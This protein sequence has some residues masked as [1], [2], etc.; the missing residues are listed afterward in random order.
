MQSVVRWRRFDVLFGVSAV[1]V[2]VGLGLSAPGAAEFGPREVIA[3]YPGDGGEVGQFAALAQDVEGH[4]HVA[5]YDALAGDLKYAFGYA[6]S[7]AAAI[8]WSRL[9]AA[10]EGDVGRHCDL[11]LTSSGNPVITFR[12]ETEG[13]LKAAFLVGT[14]TLGPDGTLLTPTEFTIETID[15]T[16]PN[17]GLYSS[18]AIDSQNL[19]HVAY[20][21]E[22]NG[23]LLYARR[24]AGGWVSEIVDGGPSQPVGTFAK[25]VINERRDPPLPLIFYQADL[26][27]DLRAL[28][29]VSPQAGWAAYASTGGV[30]D[31]EGETGHFID[32]A[33]DPARDRFFVA[34]QRARPDLLSRADLRLAILEGGTTVTTELVLSCRVDPFITCDPTLL[35]GNY[36]HYASIA[37]DAAGRP[38]IAHYDARNGG[39]VF[40]RR[41]FGDLPPFGSVPQDLWDIQ[42]RLERRGDVGLY[43]SS[44]SHV[45]ADGEAI[46]VAF[47][48]ASR[49]ALRLATVRNN[50]PV[51]DESIFIDGAKVGEFSSL[52]LDPEGRSVAAYF[53]PAEGSLFIT[54]RGQKGWEARR[55]VDDSSGPG[56]VETGSETIDPRVSPVYYHETGQFVGMVL[57]RDGVAHMA[58]YD[59]LRRR[60]NYSTYDFAAETA[61]YHLIEDGATRGQY[62]AQAISPG[63][64]RFA[65]AYYQAADPLARPD[66]LGPGPALRVALGDGFDGWTVHRVDAEGDVGQHCSVALE[67]GGTAHVAYLDAG[68]FNLKYARG[69]DSGWS[70]E[71]VTTSLAFDG[72]FTSI[73]LHPFTGEPL[74]AYYDASSSAVR[75]AERRLGTWFSEEVDGAGNV[76]LYSRLIVH[77]PTDTI[78]VVYYDASRGDLK[79]AA[80]LLSAGGPWRRF[81]IDDDGDVGWRPSAAV[82]ASGVLRVAYYDVGRGDLLYRESSHF[83]LNRVPSTWT[84]R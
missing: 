84:L 18:I 55:L 56:G 68:S 37:L 79:A 67:A 12:D 42:A 74:I 52:G 5:Y 41:L 20:K 53:D 66:P 25:I 8:V 48:D 47:Y 70:R 43:T 31:A 23:R 30:L 11:A 62:A 16:S 3:A 73:A 61:T 10:A 19:I 49:T 29:R 77:A 78:F 75:L 81:I 27:L 17:T 34:Y 51:A 50:A 22:A 9:T 21:D 69:G 63:G 26:P 82:D 33:A 39:L 24:P 2:G 14:R 72:F 71:F 44:T 65:V 7:G 58:Y 36:G 76:G 32:A 38:R 45:Y 46:R 57:D 83:L 15:A 28:E 54:R 35:P 1:T 6:P 4:L 59:R 60:L 80:R 40:E 64:D 13:S